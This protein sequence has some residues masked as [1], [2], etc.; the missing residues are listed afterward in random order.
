VKCEDIFLEAS[1][2]WRTYLLVLACCAAG[3]IMEQAPA[4]GQPGKPPPLAGWMGVFPEMSGYQRTFLAPVVNADP[5]KSVYRQT[6]KYEWTGGAIKRLEVTLARDPA[7]QQLFSAEAVMKQPVKP[8]QVKIGK[9]TGWLWK[10]E[11]TDA[12]ED[13]P[14]VARLVIL[15]A[16]DRILM[17]EARGQGPWEEL[18]QRAELF[19]LHRCA[20]TLDRPPRTDFGRKLEYFRDLKK[21]M[22]YTEA[23]AWV[24]HADK[25]IGSGIHVMEYRLGDGSRVLLGYPDFERLIY[26]RHVTKDGK[27]ED[28]LK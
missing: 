7:L 27:G 10:V 5:A 18:A 20:H 23:A 14:L 16:D 25:D 2:N 26:A 28:L 21:G 4:Q 9:H 8:T 11:R 12:K 15:L 13:W 6:V 24:G 17:L 3:M 1:M 19:D 22:S